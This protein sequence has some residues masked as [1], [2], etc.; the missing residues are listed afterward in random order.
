M[1]SVLFLALSLAIDAFAAA[2]C[3]GANGGRHGLRWRDSLAVG[4]WFGGFQ[5]GMTLIGGAFGHR[6]SQYL[7]RAG[8]L[9][10]FGLLAFLGLGMV[11][12]ALF[13]EKEAPSRRYELRPLSLATLALATSLDALAAGVS[14]AYLGQ[15]L[16]S[17][18]LVIGAVAFVLSAVGGL[19][20]QSVGSRLHRW[21]D[22][23]GGMVLIGL[24]IRVLLK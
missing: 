17:T 24:G 21:A 7:W 11:W 5:M 19:L 12:E 8:Q 18:A 23:A 22:L 4:L 20:G 6:L 15:E 10:A 9:A 3:C 13:P 14:L 2:V 16:L 1:L